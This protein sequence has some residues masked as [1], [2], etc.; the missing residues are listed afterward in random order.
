MKARWLMSMSMLL[1]IGKSI[2][3]GKTSY[4]PSK[5]LKASFTFSWPSWKTSTSATNNFKRPRSTTIANVLMKAV[6]VSKI[7]DAVSALE[8]WKPFFLH[9]F[10]PFSTIHDFYK[11]RRY[12]KHF[13]FENEIHTST[14]TIFSPHY[15][16]HDL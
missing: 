7:Q 11:D 2:W 6:S 5:S 8:N 13:C 1:P 16:F 9:S 12:M 14:F 3:T 10:N 4:W 15:T